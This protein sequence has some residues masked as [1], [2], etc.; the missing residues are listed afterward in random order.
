MCWIMLT[1]L[2]IQSPQKECG[3]IW[4]IVKNDKKDQPHEKAFILHE[5]K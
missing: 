3:I 4:K 2:L 5:I 1:V